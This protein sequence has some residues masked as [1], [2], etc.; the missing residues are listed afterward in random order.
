[1][2]Q[3]KELEDILSQDKAVLQSDG[4]FKIQSSL[5][6]DNDNVIQ[7]SDDDEESTDSLK[8]KICKYLVFILT[9]FILKTNTSWELSQDVIEDGSMKAIPTARSFADDFVLKY[10]DITAIIFIGPFSLNSK[11]LLSINFH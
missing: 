1:M 2:I 8:C 9:I 3:V 4:K 6:S 11:F 5:S 10:C 7:I